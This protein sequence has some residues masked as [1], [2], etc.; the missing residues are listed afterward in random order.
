MCFWPVAQ[1]ELEDPPKKKKKEEKP[2]YIVV[3]DQLNM[4]PIVSGFLYL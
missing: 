4:Q 1:V 3:S 2:E